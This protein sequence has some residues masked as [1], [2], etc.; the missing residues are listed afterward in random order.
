[1]LVGSGV[2]VFL[3]DRVNP[4]FSG[5]WT[6]PDHDGRQVAVDKSIAMPDSGTADGARC[7]LGRIGGC[8]GH[9][10]GHGVLT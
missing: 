2:S 3:Y 5:S 8:G 9:W 1:M 7:H 6:V 4:A 10:R